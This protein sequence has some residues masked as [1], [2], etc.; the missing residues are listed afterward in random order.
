MKIILNYSTT[1]IEALIQHLL[2]LIYHHISSM[3]GIHAIII[4]ISMLDVS[5]DVN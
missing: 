3:S 2:Q 4:D 1:M 5:R